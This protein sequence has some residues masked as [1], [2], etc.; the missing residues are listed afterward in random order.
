MPES[1]TA[2]AGSF[3]RHHNDRPRV[4]LQDLAI[5]GDFA[6]QPSQFPLPAA[7][8]EASHHEEEG[9]PRDGQAN[10]GRKIEVSH[11]PTGRQDER[12]EQQ[13][14]CRC[15]SAELAPA[16]RT[17]ADRSWHVSVSALYVKALGLPPG[18]PNNPPKQGDD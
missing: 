15:R 13:V 5:R 14:T 7:Q 12:T 9:Q 8:G 17:E 16:Y 11:D 1:W 3:L 4:S 18:C 10:T 2:S 6:N